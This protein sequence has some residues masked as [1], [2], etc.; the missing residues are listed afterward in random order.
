MPEQKPNRMLDSPTLV[1]HLL[2]RA[3]WAIEYATIALADAEHQH[4]NPPADRNEHPDP[5]DVLVSLVVIADEIRSFL[6]MPPREPE[7]K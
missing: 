4:Y 2:A 5:L 7:C 3:L 1:S 6:G